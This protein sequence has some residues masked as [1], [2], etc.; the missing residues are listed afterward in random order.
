MPT[1][2]RKYNP[3]GLYL[4]CYS[5]GSGGELLLLPPLRRR[6]AAAE[7]DEC[8]V[9][10]IGQNAK[11]GNFTP[12]ALPGRHRLE[13]QLFPPGKFVFWEPPEGKSAKKS[14]K[15]TFGPFWSPPGGDSV[16]LRKDSRVRALRGAKVR[17]SYFLYFLHF[18]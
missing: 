4:T 9:D 7:C 13:Y 17:K 1:L 11:S 12:K 3:L 2:F 14:E 18:H 8:G 5:R 15:C 16:K 10:P 6:V